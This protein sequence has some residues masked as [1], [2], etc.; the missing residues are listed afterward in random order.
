MV[1]FP[2]TYAP[3]PYIGGHLKLQLLLFQ[4]R[5]NLRTSTL[6]DTL[7]VYMRAKTH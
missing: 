5:V 2:T 1:P 3:F 7:T 4:E 6:A